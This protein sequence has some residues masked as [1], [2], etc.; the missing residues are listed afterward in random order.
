MLQLLDSLEVSL[1]AYSAE[2]DCRLVDRLLLSA[3]EGWNLEV[4]VVVWNCHCL[5]CCQKGPPPGGTLG[6]GMSQPGWEDLRWENASYC[7]YCIR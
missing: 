6:L 5:D 4:A 7:P 1:E 2:L 3:A